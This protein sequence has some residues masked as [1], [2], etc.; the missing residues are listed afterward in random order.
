MAG[1]PVG[2]I[3]RSDQPIVA[4]RVL[5]VGNGVGSATYGADGERA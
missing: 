2:L 3:V 1:K 5:Y 4:E